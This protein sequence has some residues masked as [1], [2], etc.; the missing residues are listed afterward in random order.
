MTAKESY[1]VLYDGFT[2]VLHLGGNLPWNE[3]SKE[4]FLN[5]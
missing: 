2:K 1:P 3:Q 4:A 5:V